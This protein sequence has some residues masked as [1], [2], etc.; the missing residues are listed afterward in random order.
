ME[1]SIL[2]RFIKKEIVLKGL[3]IHNRQCRKFIIKGNNYYEYNEYN[4]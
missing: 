3:K 4:E 2:F 1:H